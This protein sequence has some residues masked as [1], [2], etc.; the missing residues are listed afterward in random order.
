MARAAMFAVA[1]LHDWRVSL[2]VL[3]LAVISLLFCAI[4]GQSTSSAATVASSLGPAQAE[5][6]LGATGTRILYEMGRV[7]WR[8]LA[9]VVGA[10]SL[11]RLLWL[12]IP[13]WQLPPPRNAVIMNLS[14]SEDEKD[15]SGPLC[16]AGMAHRSSPGGAS[17]TCVAERQGPARW[18]PGLLYLGILVLIGTASVWSKTEE[19]LP[20]PLAVGQS[21]RIASADGLGLRLDQI[22]VTP[23]DNAN[24]AVTAYVTATR[25]DG[26]ERKVTLRYG[27]PARVWGQRLHLLDT[28][29]A[30]RVTARD[31]QGGA[32]TVYHLV[33]AVPPS[34]EFRVTFPRGQGEEL[35]AIPD[36]DL[37]L[38]LVRYAQGGTEE[39]EAFEVQVYEGR[40]RALLLEASV[41]GATT[42]R[43]GTIEVALI[44]EP[45]VD[46]SVGREFRSVPLLIA[47][48][49]LLIGGGAGLRWPRRTVWLV[50][51]P[52]LAEGGLL[53]VSRSQAGEPWVRALHELLCAA[54]ERPGA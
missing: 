44:P 17:D 29:P 38:R 33:G 1:M 39:T 54:S 8:F 52:P 36:A 31:A 48:A 24:V 30:L 18:L 37:V 7:S 28:G 43:A 21:R 6:V 41:G 47:A 3:I 27:H 15:Y 10:I 23:V 32:L 49:L 35:L 12:W 25:S 5:S 51:T 11:V 2:G 22:T 13:T 45:Y 40:S 19:R 50:P 53:L 14:N 26:Q 9:A 42:L 34:E 16:F 20:V 4:L 46:L